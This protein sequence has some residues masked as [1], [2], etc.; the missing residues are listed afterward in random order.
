MQKYIA[1]FPDTV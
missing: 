1:P